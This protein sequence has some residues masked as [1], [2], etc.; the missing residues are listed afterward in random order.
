MAYWLKL[1]GLRLARGTRTRL[2]MSG[3]SWS[4]PGC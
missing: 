3:M 1:L 4:Q 2:A